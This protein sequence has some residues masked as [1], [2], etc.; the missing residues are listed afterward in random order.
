MGETGHILLVDG[1]NTLSR[2]AHVYT[3]ARREDG[4]PIGGLYGLLNMTRNFLAQHPE[5]TSAVVVVDAGRPAFR[6][7]LCPEY[8]AQREDERRKNPEQERVYEAYK[9]QMPHVRHVCAG[10]NIAFARAKG[11]E[12]DDVLA[13]LA[14][15]RFSDR[16]VTV[17]STDQD[18]IELVRPGRV[19]VYNPNH[20]KFVDEDRFHVLDRLLDPK[21]SD[22]LDGVPGIGAAKAKLLTR[23]WYDMHVAT[24]EHAAKPLKPDTAAAVE[25]F[26]QWCEY[27]AGWKPRA[28]GVTMRGLSAEARL[29]LLEQREAD[30]AGQAMAKLA[31]KVLPF[32]DKVRANYKVTCL[33][34]ISKECDAATKL[35]VP[36]PA[37][38]GT[39]KAMLREYGLIPLIQEMTAVWPP[40][41]A[42]DNAW[43]AERCSQPLET[44]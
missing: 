22:N 28:A 9:Q 7:E 21:A 8:K 3:E 24:G 2:A 33:R 10:A 11:W 37:S 6:S 13:A 43:M 30:K 20:H 41:A 29:E 25:N 27:V 38:R 12:G 18:F 19:R 5:H 4:L 15:R 32:A 26:L 16:K 34:R 35:V 1:N 42:L 17:Y 31:A 44:V 36:A 40:L 39:F 14:L 23:A